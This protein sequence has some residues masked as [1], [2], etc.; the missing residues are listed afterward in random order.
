MAVLYVYHL[1]LSFQLEQANEAAS[2]CKYTR[3]D[4][5][6]RVKNCIL[7]D[8]KDWFAYGSGKFSLRFSE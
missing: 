3:I 7:N 2:Y 1:T 8:K 5:C 4:G 6:A